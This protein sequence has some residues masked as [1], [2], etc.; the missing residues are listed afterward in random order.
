MADLQLMNHY[1]YMHVAGAQSATTD[2]RVR[3]MWTYDVPQRAVGCEFLMQAILSFAALHLHIYTPNDTKMRDLSHHYFG[4][5]L[6]MFTQSLSTLDSHNADMAFAASVL[7][8]FQVFMNWKDPCGD[9]SADYEPP[10][11]WLEMCQGVASLLK[12]GLRSMQYSCMRPLIETGPHLLSTGGGIYP[13][14]HTQAA[15]AVE[16]YAPPFEA[17]AE[18]LQADSSQ[19][20]PILDETFRLIHSLYEFH[21]TGD[22]KAWTR[23]RLLTFPIAVKGGFVELLRL[24]D[25]RAL[26]IMAYYFAV[27]KM[28]DDIWWLVFFFPITDLRPSQ[29]AGG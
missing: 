10:V 17:M 25:P 24:S 23:R 28:V 18:F 13:L 12:S 14:S 19:E 27:M 7:I 21:I 2:P 5:A 29:F 15:A 4:T 6:R 11:T 22:C 20:K 26:V 8:Q 3:Q 16:E 9:S 1:T